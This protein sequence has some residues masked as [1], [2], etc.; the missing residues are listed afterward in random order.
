M[1][2]KYCFECGSEIVFDLLRP[3]LSFKVE[4]SVVTRDQR[5]DPFLQYGERTEVEF[6]C[7]KNKD[8][9]IFP[10]LDK[11]YIEF[12]N[13]MEEITEEIFKKYDEFNKEQ[14]S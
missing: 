8:H 2:K 12:D 6:I 10:K 4:D 1:N 11:D 7:S 3:T 9:D 5:R 14:N 13:W